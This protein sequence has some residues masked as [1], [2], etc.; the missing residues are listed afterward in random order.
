VLKNKRTG[1]TFVE[2]LVLVGV[3]SIIAGSIL[4]VIVSW[5]R[6]WNISKVQ[7][8]VQSQARRAMSEITEE[9]SQTSQNNVSINLIG[10]VITF[11]LPNDDYFGGAFTWGDQIQYSLISESAGISQLQRTNL[12]T[13]QIKIL[14]SYINRIQFTLTNGIISMQLTV[15][16]TP[17]GGETPVTIQLDSRVSLRN[18]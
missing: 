6:S 18:L 7:M 13:G 17:K 16:K 9:L 2:I 12:T 15:D 5:Q 3:V 10:D 1:F 11:R 4:K 14:A 8:D